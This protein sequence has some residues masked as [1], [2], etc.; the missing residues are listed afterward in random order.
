MVTCVDHFK[1]AIFVSM[2]ALHPRAVASP[3]QSHR[4]S[5]HFSGISTS[6]PTVSAAEKH[7]LR[8]ARTRHVRRKSRADDMDVM[9]AVIHSPI[10]K[11]NRTSDLEDGN[12]D[13]D[14]DEDIDYDVEDDFQSDEEFEDEDELVEEIDS[15]EEFVSDEEFAEA[16][17][18]ALG[19][20]APVILGSEA[21]KHA[22]KMRR[23]QNKKKSAKTLIEDDIRMRRMSFD[24]LLVAADAAM[25]DVSMNTP[26]S[27]RPTNPTGIRSQRRRNS[28]LLSSDPNV[29][30]EVSKHLAITEARRKERADRPRPFECP[31]AGCNKSFSQLAHL[32]IHARLFCD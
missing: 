9:D 31:E 15:C 10:A 27:L 21:L 32:K 24:A 11:N 5:G 16:D 14:D 17:A 8:H 29:V 22:L 7:L 30:A 25:S 19:K 6:L 18:G 4:S 12:M 20:S 3:S 2:T 13:E 28:S 23:Q 26:N 1:S